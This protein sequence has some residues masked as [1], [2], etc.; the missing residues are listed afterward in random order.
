MLLH[1]FT[2]KRELFWVTLRQE[3]LRSQLQGPGQLCSK[4]ESKCFIDSYGLMQIDL[5]RGCID[6]D[7]KQAPWDSTSMRREESNGW[8]SC[9]QNL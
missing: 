7:E 4:V 1:I 5:C 8:G 6:N 3:T 2:H 9:G